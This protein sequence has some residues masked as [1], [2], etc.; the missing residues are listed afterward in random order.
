MK[1]MLQAIS[2]AAMI[3][4]IGIALAFD[5]HNLLTFKQAMPAELICCAIAATLQYITNGKEMQS[6]DI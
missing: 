5:Q 1:R 6:D 4:A 3:S 2:W